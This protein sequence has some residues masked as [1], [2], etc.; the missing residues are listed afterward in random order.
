MKELHDKVRGTEYDEVYNEDF[1]LKSYDE[2][3]PH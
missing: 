2:L 3:L 1:Y